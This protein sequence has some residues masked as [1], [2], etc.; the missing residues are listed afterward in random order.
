MDT[1]T[2]SEPNNTESTTLALISATKLVVKALS[3]NNSLEKALER[4]ERLEESVTTAPA[5]T[6]PAIMTSV[7]PQIHR[8]AVIS[9]SVEEVTEVIEGVCT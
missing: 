2:V 6:K 5:A 9:S 7:S 3:D 1:N 4:E 8:I